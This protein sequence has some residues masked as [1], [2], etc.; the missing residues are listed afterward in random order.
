MTEKQFDQKMR[1]AIQSGNPREVVVEET[2]RQVKQ[3][4]PLD[5]SMILF[6][7]LLFAASFLLCFEV[8]YWVIQDW[9]WLI[10]GIALIGSNL[11]SAVVMFLIV[12]I[13]QE[14][15]Y[16]MFINEKEV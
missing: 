3:T 7:I 15:L 14:N 6:G 12:L 11:I 4:K 8:A 10:V 5:R 9:S 2:I 16:Q 13:K 1:N